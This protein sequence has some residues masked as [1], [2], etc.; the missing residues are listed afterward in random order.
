M[1]IECLHGVGQLCND[2]AH[3]INNVAVIVAHGLIDRRLESA[4]ERVWMVDF[5]E[6]AHLGR[7]RCIWLRKCFPTPPGSTLESMGK[8][9][10][11]KE[12]QNDFFVFEEVRTCAR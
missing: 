3:A 12:G 9:L 1:S 10:G 11:Q 8:A 4:G 2:K 5:V 6:P 7:P